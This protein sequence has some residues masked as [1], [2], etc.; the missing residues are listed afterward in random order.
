MNIPAFFVLILG[1]TP[2]FNDCWAIEGFVADNR[3]AA[4]VSTVNPD[5]STY[6]D[7]FEKPKANLWDLAQLTYSKS[8][9]PNFKRAD[10]RYADGGLVIETQKGHFSKAGYESRFTLSGDF[11]IQIDCNT[12]FSKKLNGMEERVIFSIGERDKD[13]R[14]AAFAWI[15]LLNKPRWSKGIMEPLCRINKKYKTGK[16]INMSDFD[17]S[18]RFVRESKKLSMHYRQK[19]SPK[20]KKLAT[21]NYSPAD[22]KIIFYVSNYTLESRSITSET[23]FKARFQAFQINAAQYIIESDI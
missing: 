13:W 15:Q 10:I 16:K 22:M 23:Q 14:D 21:M 8:Q 7:T 20:W 12:K 6:R 4:Q 11:D 5:L 3:Q 19:N 1:L 18:L 2:I 9:L 17:G